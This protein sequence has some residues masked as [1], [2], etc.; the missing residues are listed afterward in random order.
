[1]KKIKLANNT[2]EFDNRFDAGEDI[3][4]LID[5][6]QAKAIY[7]GKKVRITLDIPASLVKEIDNIREKIGIDRAALIKVWLHE[8]VNQEKTVK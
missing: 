6:S 8:R 5:L 7:H 4:D 1:M 2:E 3:H